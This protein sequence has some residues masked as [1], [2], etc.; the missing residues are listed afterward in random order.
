MQSLKK[1]HTFT[2]KQLKKKLVKGRSIQGLVAACVYAACRDTETP[3]TLDNVADGI[4]IRRKDVARCYRLVFRELDLKVPVADPINGIPRIASVAGLGE[5][6]KRKAVEILRKAKKIGV[7]A[8]KDPTGLAAAAL[9]LA[10]ITEGG[11]KTQKEISE[12]SGVT[13]VTIRNRC[14]GLKIFL[15]N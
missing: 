2:E 8:G 10:C 13:E 12:A 7:V 5:K 11:N 4:N 6:T 1:L 15:E 3:R 9:Y 14:A